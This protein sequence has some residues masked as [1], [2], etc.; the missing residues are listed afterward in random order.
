MSKQTGESRENM[1]K[2]PYF[3]ACLHSDIPWLDNN[4]LRLKMVSLSVK[5]SIV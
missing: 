3:P 1:L 5:R 4:A 2:S